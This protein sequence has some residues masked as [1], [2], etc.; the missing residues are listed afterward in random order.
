[1]ELLLLLTYSGIAIAI[2]KIFRIPA[3]AFT[4]LTAVLGGIVL[5][6]ALLL[7]MNYNHPFSNQGRFYFT[8]T[9]IVPTVGG[10]VTEVPVQPNVPLKAG[11]VLFRI[12]PERYKNAVKAKE[13]ALADALQVAEQLKA[14]ASTATNNAKAAAAAR[15][16]AQDI[17]MRSKKLIE[18]GSISQAQFKQSEERFFGARSQADAAQAEA[19]RAA[20]EASSA[21]EGVN[22]DVARIQSELDTARF[23]LEQTVVRAPTDGVVLQLFLRPGMYAVPMPLRPVIVFM[24]AEPP[25][26]AA[27]F[28]QNSSQRIFEGAE[29]EV[30]LPAVPGRFFKAKVIGSGAYIPQGQLQPSGTLVDPEQIRGEGRVIVHLRF[31]DDL[32]KFQ[33]VPGSVGNAAIY[34]HH[35]HHL[36]VMRK[37]LLRMKSW[38]NFIFGDGH[39]SGGGGGGH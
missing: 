38:T 31:E 14:A 19:E 8:T 3:N 26:F 30:I 27:A 7:G 18:S 22:T 11:D 34:T 36:A 25:V 23:D 20:L 1:M 24:P 39:A 35:M 9:P 5:I 15:D 13:A 6:G 12:E 2:F 16:A 33:I 4:L 32:S 29:A 37:I 17:Y 28:L 10:R 21:I